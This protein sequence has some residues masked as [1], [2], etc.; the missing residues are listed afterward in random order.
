[1]SQSTVDELSGW[2]APEHR[3][4][5]KPGTSSH[6]FATGERVDYKGGVYGSLPEEWNSNQIRN[7]FFKFQN[8]L[9]DIEQMLINL[10]ASINVAI[11]D[12][13]TTLD[14]HLA[15]LESHEKSN[16][17]FKE[18]AKL[19]IKR[20]LEAIYKEVQ[21]VLYQEEGSD[22]MPSEPSTDVAEESPIEIGEELSPE[23]VEE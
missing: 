10:D 20:E 13:I 7:W 22:N 11:A 21:E 12:H 6:Q 23:G 4:F 14:A 9:R 2:L 8:K 3:A 19:Y 18:E 17:Q 15:K 1:M 16:E 5:D